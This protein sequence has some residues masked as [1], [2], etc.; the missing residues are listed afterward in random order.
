MGDPQRAQ[1]TRS[2]PGEDSYSRSDDPP[3][4]SVNLCRS[5][6]EFAPKALPLALRHDVQ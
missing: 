1:K 4:D 6:G 2:L 3:L 5:T